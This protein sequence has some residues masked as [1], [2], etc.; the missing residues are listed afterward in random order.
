M[1]HGSAKVRFVHAGGSVADT[2]EVKL[3]KLMIDLKPF[4]TMEYRKIPSKEYNI[5][6]MTKGTHEKLGSVCF[7]FPLRSGGAVV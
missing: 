2:V 4:E 6:L 1:K 3:D 7:F 5:R